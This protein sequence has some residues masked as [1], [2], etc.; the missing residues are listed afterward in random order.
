MHVLHAC[1]SG[2]RPVN[3]PGDAYSSLSF[4][5]SFSRLTLS[6]PFSVQLTFL[7]TFIS[8]HNTLLTNLWSTENIFTITAD[9]PSAVLNGATARTHFRERHKEGVR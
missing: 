7:L 6:I 3:W 1:A 2:V 8:S 5:C 4:I 9:A